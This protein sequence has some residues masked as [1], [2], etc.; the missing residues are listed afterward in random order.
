MMPFYRGGHARFSVSMETFFL[1]DC[2]WGIAL[3]GNKFLIIQKNKKLSQG[4]ILLHPGRSRGEIT[5]S[6]FNS[7][8]FNR[9]K[10][11]T[12]PTL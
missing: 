9:R 10:I 4:E 1:Y 3:L 11:A 6:F 2:L 12:S 7:G 5:C 8:N